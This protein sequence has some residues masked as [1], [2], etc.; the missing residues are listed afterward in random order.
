MTEACHVKWQQFTGQKMFPFIQKTGSPKKRTGR[1]K[2][3]SKIQCS[4]HQLCSVCLSAKHAFLTM[5]L[6]WGI[7][8]LPQFSPFEF[9][10]VDLTLWLHRWA[11]GSLWANKQ[12]FCLPS[13][14]SVTDWCR[15]Q[16][17]STEHQLQAVLCIYWKKAFLPLAGVAKLVGCKP[18]WPGAVF[19]TR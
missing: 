7:G 5:T 18:G 19:V 10:V 17:T 3:A 1:T 14:D 11:L 12:E 8:L 16:N 13:P 15:S 2:N 9:G 4:E 6:L